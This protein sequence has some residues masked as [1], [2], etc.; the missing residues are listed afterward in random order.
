LI[1]FGVIFLFGIL[2]VKIINLS[3]PNELDLK[4]IKLIGVI[5]SMTPVKNYKRV[6]IKA[7]YFEDNKYKYKTKLKIQAY[8]SDKKKQ[9]ANIGEE[10]ILKGELILPE[11]LRNPGGFDEKK[12]YMTNNIA[13][14]IF[15]D[16][17]INLEQKEYLNFW[18]DKFKNKL[19]GVY[20]IIF[21]EREA[22]IIKSMLLGDKSDL[23]KYTSDLYKS[24]GIYHIL[25]ISGLHISI[26]ALLISFLLRLIL[27]KKIASVI[28][29]ISLILYCMMVGNNIST[30]RAV[31]MSS[32]IIFGD[33][34]YRERDLLSSLAFG[35]LCLLIYNPF[36][37]YNIGFEYSFGAVF[38]IATCT[39]QIDRGLL[40]LSLKIKD[41]LLKKNISYKFI[42]MIDFIIENKFIKKYFAASCAASLITC[43]VTVF[44]FYYFAPYSIFI[45]LFVLPNIALVVITGFLIGLIGLISLHI[46]SFISGLVFVL[47]KFYELIS[48][49]FIALPCARIL[50]G[51]CHVIIIIFYFI[52]LFLLIY[53]L[54][55]FENKFVIIKK[56]FKIYSI[57]LISLIL[58]IKILP[59]APEV[60]MLDV[61]Q[62]DCFVINNKF[63][64]YI[65][66]GGGKRT[67]EIGNN[68]GVNILIPFLD[69]QAKN[70]IDYVFVT[71]SDADHIIGI[72]EL[73]DAKRVGKIFV[74]SKIIH[75]DLYKLLLERANKN[76]I[77]LEFIKSHDILDN[78]ECI[79]PFENS[80]VKSSNDSSLV[81]KLKLKDTKILFTGDIESRGEQEI[82]DLNL[83]IKS[84]IL[85][86]AH[87]GSKTSSQINFLEHVAP[88]L[89]I[90]STGKNNSYGHPSQEVLASLKKFNIPV[91][92]TAESG[93]VRIKI[94]EKNK[95]KISCMIN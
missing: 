50:T 91:I 75:D 55:N 73:L 84:D 37:I 34:I 65:I 56:Y 31:I 66:D 51:N 48:R 23:D 43:C 2:R 17:I 74:S 33:L 32:I 12:Y 38:G 81:L 76:L 30:L 41:L 22:G 20:E 95:T 16:E 61:G 68:T 42:S 27:D 80:L 63:K 62:G 67:Q 29:I 5:K 93:A 36:G 25:A 53:M 89:A 54:N 92:N 21:S 85:K 8:L 57:C 45:N 52:W 7:N 11:N 13:Y 44:Y 9:V 24:A 79:F 64:T 70:F 58:L 83:D 82:L 3:L 6:I 4:N 1:I 59:R 60:I 26:I 39:E 90:V 49:L 88:C 28:I 18:L 14:K 86:L 35:F 40:L 47:L 69:Y 15:P 71:H 46:A 10:V 19:A 72:I 87:H 94:L 78:F 77:K